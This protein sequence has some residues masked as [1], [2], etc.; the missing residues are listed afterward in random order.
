MRGVERERERRESER[1]RIFMLFMP[2]WYFCKKLVALAKLCSKVLFIILG[3]MQN[4]WRTSRTHTYTFPTIW[5]RQTKPLTLWKH[6]RYVLQDKR[7]QTNI[8]QTITLIKRNSL[9]SLERDLHI[10][11]SVCFC[12]WLYENTIIMCSKTNDFRRTSNKQQF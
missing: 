10:H 12:L 5:G 8:Q 1:N 9:V 6:N 4:N 7:F 2:K 3:V 11:Y